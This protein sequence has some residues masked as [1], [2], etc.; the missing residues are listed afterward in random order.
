[1]VRLRASFSSKRS[2]KNCVQWF[3]YEHVF[4]REKAGDE[5]V[6][7]VFSIIF[8]ISLVKGSCTTNSTAFWIAIADI[9]KLKK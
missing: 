4:F 6:A 5:T 9:R 1:M 7:L 3:A 2:Q 8:D